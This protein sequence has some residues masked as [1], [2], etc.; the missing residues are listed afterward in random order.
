MRDPDWAH[1]FPAG[2][3]DAA[4]RHALIADGAG[5]GLVVR[6][7]DGQRLWRGSEPVQPLLIDHELAI[8]LVLAPPRILARTLQGH[9]RWCS[10]PLPWPAWAAQWPQLNAAS[11]LRAAWLDGDVVL[12]WRLRAPRGGGAGRDGK[13]PSPSEGGCRL[14]RD[15]GAVQVL[16]SAPWPP[17]RQAGPSAS[18]DPAVL[19]QQLLAGKRYALV[20]RLDGGR[21]HSALQAHDLDD[22][23][24]PDWTCPIDD[25]EPEPARPPRP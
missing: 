13:P 3:A 7:A 14:R 2:V 4:G 25:I 1:P 18:E 5:H 6:L 24:E 9:E 22:A 20:Q 15:S 16:D 17:D 23:Q 11:D 19:A 8:M 21:L 12:S 10:P